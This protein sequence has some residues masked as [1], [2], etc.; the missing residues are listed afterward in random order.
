MDWEVFWMSMLFFFIWVPV[1]LM[2]MFAIVDL[3]MRP[4]LSGWGKAGWLLAIVLLPILGTVLYFVFRPL[5]PE[6]RTSWSSSG[7]EWGVDSPQRM[8]SA[9]EASQRLAV[10]SD[11]REK[12]IITGE[13]FDHESAG[14]RGAGA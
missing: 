1:V 10:L 14:L 5:S 11:L 13:Q 3:F 4:D 7:T 2:W 9:S 8:S 6:S 12:G